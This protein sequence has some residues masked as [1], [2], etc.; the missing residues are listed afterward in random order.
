M[1]AIRQI[2]GKKHFKKLLIKKLEISGFDIDTKIAF[3]LGKDADVN[4]LSKNCWKEGGCDSD[5]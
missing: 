2:I 4:T 1:T 5:K 3:A